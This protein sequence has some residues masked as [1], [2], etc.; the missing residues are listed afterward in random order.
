MISL[1][2]MPLN[3]TRRNLARA[4]SRGEADGALPRCVRTFIRALQEIDMADETLG[5]DE[6]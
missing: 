2:R 6:S 4:A 5:T 1:T 3:P